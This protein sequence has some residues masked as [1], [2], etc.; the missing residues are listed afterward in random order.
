M[1]KVED[2]AVDSGEGIPADETSTPAEEPDAPEEAKETDVPEEVKETRKPV[3]LFADEKK[4]D[5][6]PFL[7]VAGVFGLAVV[8]LVLAW[9][10]FWNTSTAVYFAGLTFIPLLLWLGR[11]TNTVYVVFLA[12]AIAVLM[13]SIYWLWTV[14]ATR[15]HFDTKAAERTG[16]VQPV[17]RGLQMAIR[18][19]VAETL[20]DC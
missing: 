10:G 16:M 17:D 6:T 7:V 11:K 18:A 2:D 4:T 13:T 1:D 5:M 20:S 9:A 12:C 19:D 15:Y 3:D 14:W 8:L